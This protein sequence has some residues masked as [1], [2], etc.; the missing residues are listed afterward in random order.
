MKGWNV[1]LEGLGRV[2]LLKFCSAWRTRNGIILTILTARLERGLSHEG[3]S[4][5]M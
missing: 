3:A 2:E 1:E 5:L 4:E